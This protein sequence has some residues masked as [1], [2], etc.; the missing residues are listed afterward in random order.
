[1]IWLAVAGGGA[2][3]SLLRYG[4]VVLTA[5]LGAPQWVILLINAAGSLAIGALWGLADRMSLDAVLRDGVAVGVLGSFTT[6]SAFAWDA[7]RWLQ[8]GAWLQAGLYIVATLM[9]C[10]ALAGLGYVWMRA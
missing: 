1:M 10:T 4:L 8:A 7:F 5:P 9:L 3:G 2:I 6:M